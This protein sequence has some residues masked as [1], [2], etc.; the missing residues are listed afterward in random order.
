M[1]NKNCLSKTLN[2]T[3]KEDLGDFVNYAI[4]V[5]D[6]IQEVLDDLL[7]RVTALEKK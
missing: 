2:A 4:P 3:S 7:T 5:F 1:A 6:E